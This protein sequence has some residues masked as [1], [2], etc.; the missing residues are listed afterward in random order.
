MR[1]MQKEAVNMDWEITPAEAEKFQDALLKAFPNRGD[2]EQLV[3]FR[4]G[5]HLDQI[6]G[7]GTYAKTV[8]DLIIW[9]DGEGKAWDLLCAAH[10]KNPGNPRLKAFYQSIAARQSPTPPADAGGAPTALPP[11]A[12]TP[13]LRQKLVEIVMK[14]PGTQKEDVRSGYLL[15]IPGSLNRIPGNA[16]ADLNAIFDQL[17]GLGRLASGEWPLL[18]VID[19]ILAYVQGYPD[20]ENPIQQIRQKLEQAYNNAP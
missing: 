14:I 9:A 15:G 3:F 18:L 4:L 8:S 5:Q 6:V 7:S 12:L 1:A 11:R 2:L 13:D 17:D 20:I 16:W 19:N 10:E